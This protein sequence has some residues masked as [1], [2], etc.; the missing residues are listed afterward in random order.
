MS[1][2]AMATCPT[3]GIAAPAGAS[4]CGNCGGSLTAAQEQQQGPAQSQQQPWQPQQPS[5]PNPISP[6]DSRNWAMG[7]HLTALA[8]AFFAGV[9]SFVGPLVIW[10]MR[11]EDDSFA[12]QHALEALNFN[13][14][15]LGVVIIGGI[16]SVVTLGIGL[17]VVV[18]LLLIFGVLWLIWTIQASLAASRGEVYRYPVSI[19]LIS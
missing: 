19:R 18:P 2:Q 1:D 5:G 7:A 15:T 4:F 3:C 12:A 13:L 6:A 10:L 11:R 17:I 14:M 8:G 16:L 9:A